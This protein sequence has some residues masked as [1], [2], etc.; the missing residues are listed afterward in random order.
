MSEIAPMDAVGKVEALTYTPSP[1]MKAAAQIIEA[2]EGHVPDDLHWDPLTMSYGGGPGLQGDAIELPTELMM[3]LVGP[4][5][6]AVRAKPNPEPPLAPSQER[7]RKRLQMRKEAAERAA[8]EKAA[9][10]EKQEEEE[11]LDESWIDQMEQKDAKK[12]ANREK[13]VQIRKERKK[14][15]KADA[16]AKQEALDFQEDA[17]EQVEQELP[18]EPPEPEPAEAE[19][20]EDDDDMQLVELSK[21]RRKRQAKQAKQREEELAREERRREEE[22]KEAERRRREA[23]A[24]RK[25]EEQ[26]RLEERQKR[27]E[28]LRLKALREAEEKQKEE[29]RQKQEA[30][31]RKK[32]EIRRKTEKSE[33]PEPERKSEKAE[34]KEKPK[35]KSAK[36]SGTDD[37]EEYCQHRRRGEEVEVAMAQRE[38]EQKARPGRDSAR[39]KKDKDEVKDAKS[40]DNGL[41]QA[42]ESG[43][44]PTQVKSLRQTLTPSQLRRQQRKRQREARRAAEQA[45]REEDDSEEEA[46]KPKPAER[47][48]ERKQKEGRSQE[49]AAQAEA[50]LNDASGQSDDVRKS[51]G[52]GPP[53]PNQDHSAGLGE[54]ELESDG[55]GT[56]LR[57]DAEAFSSMSGRGRRSQSQEMDQNMMMPITTL[58]ISQIPEASDAETFRHKLDSWGFIGTYNFFYMPPDVSEGWGGR[59]AFINFVDQAMATMCQ[60]YFQQCPNEGTAT[61]YQVQGLEHNIAHFSQFVGAGDMVN[62]PLIV[63]TPTPTAWA[64]NGAQAMMTSTTGKF[65]PQIRG[66]FHKTKM[67]AFHKKKKCTMGVA[68][69]FAH[70]K[71]ELNAPPDLSKT[72]LCVNFFRRKCND[73]NCKFAHG[74]SEL[75]ATG[76][77]YK[78]E[79]CRAW[80]TGTCKAGDT[81]RYAHGVNE[82]RGG[83]MAMAG[84]GYMGYGMDDEYMQMEGMPMGCDAMGGL[85]GI[86]ENEAA[87]MQHFSGSGYGSLSSYALPPNAGERGRSQSSAFSSGQPQDGTGDGFNDAMS[88]MG[89][90]DVSTLCP[91]EG[92]LSRQQTAP[93]TASFPADM[94]LAR[95]EANH[96]VVL[97]VKGTF[98][99]SVF[100]DEE[101]ERMPLRR[102]WSDG[103]LPQLQD[104]DGEHDL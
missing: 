76:S 88:D 29:E 34:P 30:A 89:L 104:I 86:W 59:C 35:E 37:P 90:S 53:T 27:E 12:K 93:P 39:E 28:E 1:F 62:G 10:Q 4:G 75:R 58:M 8:A 94:P 20:E 42:K 73:V 31:K 3:N 50:E 70:S 64:L 79:L 69:P 74:H 13:A 6:A 84:S 67:C 32:E 81:C 96:N 60:G 101:V 15:R 21:Q 5:L 78:T 24:K 77:V 56:D 92:R 49:K 36:D 87:A 16:A 83:S 26:E 71:D 25:A 72:K 19:E 66:Q 46:E 85:A 45:A 22:R 47:K 95:G 91:G 65:S 43:E 82:L 63:P 54:D 57:K 7:A 17:E 48:P 41:G 11:P 97:R 102:S 23:E 9:L 68:C 44:Q 38:A 103:D 100:L 40:C 18:V 14:A 98:M 51:V 80:S 55:T 33:E 61:P 99:E 2:S 52:S